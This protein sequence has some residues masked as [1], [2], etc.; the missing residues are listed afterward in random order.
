MASGGSRYPWRLKPAV[1]VGSAAVLTVLFA[2]LS[3]GLAALRLGGFDDTLISLIAHLESPLATGFMRAATDLGSAAV[4]VP[5][6]L[7]VAAWVWGSP[8]G[9]APATSRRQARFGALFLL[10]ALAGSW[11]FNSLLK[12]LFHRARPGLFPLVTASGYSYPSGHTMS[13]IAFYMAAAYI[14]SVTLVS[15]PRAAGPGRRARF[16]PAILAITAA[17]ATLLV[18]VSR[19]YLGVHYPSDVLGGYL[20]GGAW[21]LLS[22]AGFERLRRG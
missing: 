17:L 22:L 8:P 3:F 11:L 4:L 15:G 16:Y 5:L 20:A 2:L 14:A 7:L 9:Q 19:V 13:S 12:F 1:A 18:G 6:A 21:G 10:I